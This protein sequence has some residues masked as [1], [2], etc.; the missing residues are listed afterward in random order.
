[1]KNNFC[2]IDFGTIDIE[3][4][5]ENIIKQVTA[6]SKIAERDTRISMFCGT[7]IS[8]ILPDTIGRSL[9]DDFIH[10]A[11]TYITWNVCGELE[12]IA[13]QIK[14]ARGDE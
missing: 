11:I 7:D 9:E 12:Y 1:M 6:L 14:A 10:S 2:D 8:E 4:R 5:I 13:N 3:T